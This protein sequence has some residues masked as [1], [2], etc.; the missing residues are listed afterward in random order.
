MSSVS[1]Q[2]MLNCLT[3]GMVSA[4][5]L[6]QMYRCIVSIDMYR[7]MLQVGAHPLCNGPSTENWHMGQS[8]WSSCPC[9]RVS[10]PEGAC[11]PAHAIIYE[12]HS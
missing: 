6:V 2:P 11:T 3:A 7:G 8:C 12:D 9:S 1:P 5:L 4:D 10:H